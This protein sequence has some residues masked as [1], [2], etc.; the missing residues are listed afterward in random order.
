M[1]LLNYNF[2]THTNTH[3]CTHA[4]TH[5]HTHTHTRAHMYAHKHKHTVGLDDSMP[6]LMIKFIDSIK[7]VKNIYHMLVTF[8]RVCNE[9]F[10]YR[11]VLTKEL[12]NHD[13]SP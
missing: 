9:G 11:Y 3:A 6:K 12:N 7:I 13:F 1:S 4:R 2:H 10:T 5:T 8:I